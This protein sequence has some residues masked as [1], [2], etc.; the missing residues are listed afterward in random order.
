MAAA[1]EDHCGVS[2]ELIASGGGVFEVISTSGDTALGGTDMDKTL[3]E[4]ITA[5]FKR[6]TG[7]DL[8]KDSTAQARIIEAA[9]KAGAHYE[10]GATYLEFGRRCGDVNHLEKARDIFE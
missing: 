8:S 6:K 10:I 3:V 5:E 9:E 2:A 1:I 4:Y 7:I